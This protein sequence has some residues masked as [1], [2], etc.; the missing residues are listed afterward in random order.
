MGRSNPPLL[1]MKTK[2][3]NTLKAMPLITLLL[4]FG[5]CEQRDDVDLTS[6]LIFLGIAIVLA[7]LALICTSKIDWDAYDFN[8]ND[9]KDM[10][11]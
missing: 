10:E 8:D 6:G 4:V 2:T 1:T 7:V 3:K 11:L 5:S 9:F